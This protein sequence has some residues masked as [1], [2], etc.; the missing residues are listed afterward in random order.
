MSQS[1]CLYCPLGI[2]HTYTQNRV[3][4]VATYRL[5]RSCWIRKT[6]KKEF[7]HKFWSDF[8]SSLKRDYMPFKQ[9]E[10]VGWRFFIKM[11]EKYNT[12]KVKTTR[13]MN[14]AHMT[15]AS[16]GKQWRVLPKN[17]MRQGETRS[18]QQRIMQKSGKLPFSQAQHFVIMEPHR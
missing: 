16:L 1:A 6:F 15:K 11:S 8:A 3:T 5:N 17:S 7:V 13:M 9:A 18:Q 14:L 10:I 2:W 12:F 4:D